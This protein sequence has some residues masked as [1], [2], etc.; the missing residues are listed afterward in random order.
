MS[1]GQPLY[2]EK[3]LETKEGNPVSC[4]YIKK[5]NLWKNTPVPHTQTL[6]GEPFSEQCVPNFQ[7]RMLVPGFGMNVCSNSKPTHLNFNLKS[8]CYSDNMCQNKMNTCYD[9]YMQG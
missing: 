2:F 4:P 8:E 5:P 7:D 1:F 6:Q 9:P 3:P